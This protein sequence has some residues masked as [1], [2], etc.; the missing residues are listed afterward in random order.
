MPFPARVANRC[1]KSRKRSRGTVIAL[2]FTTLTAEIL[3]RC[4]AQDPGVRGELEK[5]IERV[6]QKFARIEQIKRFAILTHDSSQAGGE[7]TPT[8]KVK[9]AVVHDKYA[10]VFDGLYAA[11]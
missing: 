10:D 7:L 5:E 8:L 4:E 9:R 2:I 3:R 6:N 1:S 11:A